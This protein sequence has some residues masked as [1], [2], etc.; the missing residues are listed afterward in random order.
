M[1]GASVNIP[2][3]RSGMDDWALLEG[4]TQVGCGISDYRE[5]SGRDHCIDKSCII[6]RS[7]QRVLYFHQSSSDTEETWC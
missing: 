2:A 4:Y 6:S 3:F 5:L 7:C 1:D